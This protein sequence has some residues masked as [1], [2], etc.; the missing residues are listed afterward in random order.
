[1]VRK[2]RNKKTAC[3]YGHEHDSIIEAKCC[4]QLK[5]LKSAKY[6]KNYG[7]QI[8]F[9]LTILGQ[10]IGRHIPD[11]VAYTGDNGSFF[12]VDAKG[13]LLPEWSIK[14]KILLALMPQVDY[15]V[16]NKSG[17]FKLKLSPKGILTKKKLDILEYLTKVY[18]ESQRSD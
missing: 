3:N 7:V 12:F 17:W 18:R 5:Y 13:R 10:K 14:A 6:I 8:S 15:L 4:H 9:D 16:F 1:M 2:Y 11:F